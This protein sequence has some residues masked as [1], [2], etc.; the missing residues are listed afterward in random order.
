MS[1]T[2]KISKLIQVKNSTIH[3]KGVFALRDIPKGK[4]IIEYT[5]EHISWDVAVDRHPHGST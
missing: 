1:K 5:G 3:G 4:Q 2:K